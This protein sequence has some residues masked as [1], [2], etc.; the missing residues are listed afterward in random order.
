MKCL[1]AP[2]KSRVLTFLF[3]MLFSLHVACNSAPPHQAN[4]DESGITGVEEAA[5]AAGIT[6]ST[7][8]LYMAIATVIV[9]LIEVGIF[10]AQNYDA[11]DV[12][13]WLEQQRGNVQATKEGAQWLA[14]SIIDKLAPYASKASIAAQLGAGVLSRAFSVNEDVPVVASELPAGLSIE[15][16]RTVVHQALLDTVPGYDAGNWSDVFE[17]ATNTTALDNAVKRRLT[18]LSL[19]PGLEQ[20]DLIQRFGLMLRAQ[21]I[22]R[23]GHVTQA[24]AAVAVLFAAQSAKELMDK[25]LGEYER[26]MGQQIGPALQQCLS[27]CGSNDHA[28]RS[29][30][31][32]QAQQQALTASQELLRSLEAIDVTDEAADVVSKLTALIAHYKTIVDMHE[33]NARVFRNQTDAISQ[34]GDVTAVYRGSNQQ[35]ANCLARLN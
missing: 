17:Q 2:F 7:L 24:L 34:G 13:E 12:A 32:A 28:C 31:N 22:S 19:L 1:G 18:E 14:T 26:K 21:T 25:A 23:A 5:A 8:Y 9:I 20:Y 6:L 15:S 11:N 4:T 30:C 10:I 3:A 29:G 16:Y 35:I 33:C 27:S